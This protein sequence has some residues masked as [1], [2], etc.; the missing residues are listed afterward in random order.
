MKPN[1]L[2]D[3]YVMEGDAAA[4]FLPLFPAGPQAVAHAAIEPLPADPRD[5]SALVITGSAASV[6]EPEPWVTALRDFVARAV[7]VGVPVLGVCFGHQL[8]AWAR[9]GDAAVRRAARPEV[10]WMPIQITRPDP[11]FSGLQTGFVPFVS[12]QDEVIAVAEMSVFAH[13]EACAVHGFRIP[14][15]PAWGVQFHAEMA[16]EE[17]SQIAHYREAKHPDLGLDAQTLIAG[18]RDC[19]PI[20]RQIFDNFFALSRSDGSMR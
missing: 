9:W 13:T 17:V 18:F 14:D 12:H 19:Q 1:L 3:C 15:A 8:L 2:L 10:G 16:I 20:A 4:N 5:F 11:L 7:D 6:V